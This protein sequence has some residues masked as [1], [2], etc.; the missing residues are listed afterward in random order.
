[1]NDETRDPALV[2]F[3]ERRGQPSTHVLVIGIG[4]YPHLV[5]G[6]G[7]LSQHAG[8]MRQL[9]S[10]PVSAKAFADWIIR[11]LDNPG[12]PL[13]SVALL[14][15]ESKPSDFVN[16][17]T[18]VAHKVPVA[19]VD[20]VEEAIGRWADRCAENPDN[21]AVF[22]FCGH[23]VSEGA[24]SALLMRDFGLNKRNAFDGA[25]NLGELLAA[26]Q[27]RLPNRQ[28]FV[29]DSCRMSTRLS[30]FIRQKT[31]MGRTCLQAEP[32]GRLSTKEACLQSVLHSTLEGAGAYGRADKPSMY[33]EAFLTA[34]KGSGGHEASGE[35]RIETTSLQTALHHLLSKG[36]APPNRVQAPETMRSATFEVHRPDSVEIATFVT[37]RN[38]A[39]MDAATLLCERDGSEIHRVIWNAK[40]GRYWQLGLEP[41][42][43]DFGAEPPGKQPVTKRVLVYA[44]VALV[45]LEV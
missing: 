3:A 5:D 11:E 19:D 32:T 42:R 36:L 25:I 37:C 10:P 21:F 9:S 1:M 38:P 20:T 29:I 18:D 43:Y 30:N 35:W 13:S 22:F 40:D 41:D 4:D 45:E 33:T 27:T 17:R 7:E 15:S 23:G 26:M 14:L 28:L 6:T 12:R 24:V 34:L 16:S 44:P 31:A 39:A 2:H 8:G